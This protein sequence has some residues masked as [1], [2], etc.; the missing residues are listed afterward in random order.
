MTA[1]AN[2]RAPMTVLVTTLAL[3]S[4]TLL[5]VASDLAPAVSGSAQ[6]E[7]LKPTATT[8]SLQAA[9]LIGHVRW[10]EW[11]SGQ[12]QPDPLQV[13]PFTITLRSP[14]ISVNYPFMYT[15]E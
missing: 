10:E 2:H 4:A 1:K 13:Q 11:P 15:D 14:S 9:P 12:V 7:G 6:A 8:S 3:V 5:L